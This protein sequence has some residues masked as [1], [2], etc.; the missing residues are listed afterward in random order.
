MLYVEPQSE[1]LY[2]N[3]AY[4]IN[5]SIAVPFRTMHKMPTAQSWLLFCR[6]TCAI[7]KF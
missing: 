6:S 1:A 7:T 4:E 3:T 2:Q 5:N